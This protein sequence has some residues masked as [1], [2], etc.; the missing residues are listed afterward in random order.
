MGKAEPTPQRFRRKAKAQGTSAAAS[1]Q[2]SNSLITPPTTV[3]NL[4]CN[5]LLDTTVASEPE[6]S[7]SD[8]TSQLTQGLTTANG[9]CDVG[10]LADSDIKG[11]KPS[12][13]RDNGMVTADPAPHEEQTVPKDLC[14]SSHLPAELSG[15]SCSEITPLCCN[16]S[17]DLSA[18]HVQKE[19][20]LVLVVFMTNSSD[21]DIQQILLQFD[22]EEL[23]VNNLTG[24]H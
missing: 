18:C 19:D 1:E 17:L 12:L 8:Q 5:N 9:T 10:E 6:V 14:L 22:S 13:I 4:L 7:S 16:Q 24:K 21:S 15:F 23:E 20:S 11:T 3:D 2:T